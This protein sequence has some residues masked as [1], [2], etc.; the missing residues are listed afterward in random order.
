MFFFF[1]FGSVHFYWGAAKNK[2]FC[3]HTK[4]RDVEEVGRLRFLRRQH[5]LAG[6]EPF[7]SAQ[8]SRLAR[9]SLE[10]SRGVS[11]WRLGGQNR[12]NGIPWW[13]FA[14]FTEPIVGIGMFT[15]GEGDFGNL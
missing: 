7:E 2:A 13:D 14:E 10:S 4:C 9:F 1:F 8:R 11:R 15:G 12:E 3:Y 5:V 6:R